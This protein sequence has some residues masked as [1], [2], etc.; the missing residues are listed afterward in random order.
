[1]QRRNVDLPDPE[2]GPSRHITSPLATLRVMPLRTS[3]LPKRLRTLR[4]VSSGW[5]AAWMLPSS[6]VVIATPSPLPA[7]EAPGAGGP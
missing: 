4:A 6:T 7:A 3:T 5:A 2:G 1:M